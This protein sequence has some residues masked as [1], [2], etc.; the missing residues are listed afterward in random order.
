MTRSVLERKLVVFTMLGCVLIGVLLLLGWSML[1]VDGVDAL[2]QS[3]KPWF[4]VWRMVLFVG[5]IDGW[6]HWVAVAAHK[7]W[8][9]PDQVADVIGYRWSLAL[10]LLLL[11]ALFNQDVLVLIV[12]GLL[13]V[14]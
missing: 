9:H 2:N 11:E 3:L 8:I 10:W 1:G 5:V 6:S 14:L 12:D 13:K 4:Q 7:H